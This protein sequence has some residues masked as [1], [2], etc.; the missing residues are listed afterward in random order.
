MTDSLLD[1][2][3]RDY[4]LSKSDEIILNN[5]NDYEYV[6]KVIGK[7]APELLD[8]IRFHRNLRPLYAVYDIDKKIEKLFSRKIW[9]KSGAYIII[10][11]T[12]A[13]T[14]I[15]VNSGKFSERSSNSEIIL[16]INKEAAKEVSRQ[17]RLRDISG[18]IVIDFIDM[19]EEE[20]KKELI[21]YFKKCAAADKTP[22]HVLGMT[23]LGLIEMT[24]QKMGKSY[25]DV[26]FRECYKCNSSGRVINYDV[27]SLKILNEIEDTFKLMKQNKFKLDIKIELDNSFYYN[28]FLLKGFE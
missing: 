10:D 22:N 21:N 15:D 25:F 28:E 14:V 12:E 8:G 17:L 24:R 18:I 11:K 1:K 5:Y 6:N 4:Y 3:I 20:H 23:K 2:V 7:S 19:K 13:M 16:K 9:L 27:I 26:F